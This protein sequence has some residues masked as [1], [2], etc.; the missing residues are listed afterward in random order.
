MTTDQCDNTHRKSARG[1]PASAACT[2]AQQGHHGEHRHR[3]TAH[4][5]QR[6]Y[7]G[8]RGSA[9]NRI[10]QQPEPSGSTDGVEDR[11]HVP[12]STGTRFGGSRG[13]DHPCDRECDAGDTERDGTAPPNIPMTT[14][15]TTPTAS[16]GC[17]HTHR[18]DRQTLVEE[19]D[20]RSACH[21]RADGPREITGRSGEDPVARATMETETSPA[22]CEIN[23]T[24]AVS[25][26][27]DVLPPRKSAT[28]H[29]S[30]EPR[31]SR[32]VIVHPETDM[33]H[34]Y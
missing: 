11:P 2:E 29:R 9:G 25:W 17:D 15:M 18:S 3:R 22:S 20:R 34:A 6:H 33:T 23:T 7:R 21:A 13:D 8:M 32:M 28:P 24:N 31:A 12:I 4:H 27:R 26:R 19:Q 5:Q 1:L 30:D 14:G 10:L 16:D